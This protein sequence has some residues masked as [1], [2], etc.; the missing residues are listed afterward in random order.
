MISSVD[1]VNAFLLKIGRNSAN[2]CASKF[3]SW[4]DLFTQTSMQM[5][6][7]GINTKTRKYILLWREKYRQGEELCELPIMKK[8]GGGERKRLKNK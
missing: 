8:V 7:N 6:I 1:S 2:I 4:S 3:K 5:K